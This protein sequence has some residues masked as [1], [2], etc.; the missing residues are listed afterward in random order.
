MNKTFLI[1]GGAGFIGTNYV[2]RLAQRGERVIVLD[3]LSREGVET[4]LNWQKENLPADKVSFVNADV[5]H[6]DQV[7]AQFVNNEIDVVVH[8]AAQVAVTKSVQNPREDFEI[9]ALGTLNVLEAAR[10]AGRKPFVIYSS[11]N[12]VYGGLERYEAVESAT[13]YE[14]PALEHGISESEPLDFHSPYGCSKGT[15]DQYVRDYSRIYEIPTV[16]M[17]QSCIYGTHQ[18][19]IEDQGWVAWF[20]RKA[21]QRKSLTIF[22]NG[23]Q[24]R[25]LLYIDDLL[26]A[27]DLAIE[28]PDV[29][30]GKIY[31][32]GG[33]PANSMSVWAEFAPILEELFQRKL[34][35]SFAE[36]RP[37]D[38]KVYISDTSLINKDLGW[39]PRVALRDGIRRLYDW[40][41]SIEKS[42]VT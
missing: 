3:N 7:W 4:N 28:R 18:F 19:G 9:N 32:I 26:D 12:K 21:A 6:F 37:G 34:D 29:S 39:T 22:G 30:S 36:W 14:L 38:Q 11:T 42:Q 27:F 13:R 15:G 24:V 31:N 20:L 8:L 2:R 17:R 16:V 33:G 10:L 5:R 23:K 35:H 40:V 1:T 41:L 25:D